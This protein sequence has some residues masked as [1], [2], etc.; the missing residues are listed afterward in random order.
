[1]KH[2]NLLNDINMYKQLHNERTISFE[3]KNNNTIKILFEEKSLT[4]SK[5]KNRLFK[6]Q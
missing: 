4:G 6:A 5:S 1:M 2:L 3:N